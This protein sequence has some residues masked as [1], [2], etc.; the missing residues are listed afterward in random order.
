MLGAAEADALRAEHASD[1]RVLWSVSIRAHA[2]RADFIG[3][4]QQAIEV[5]KNLGLLKLH[6]AL[7]KNLN[8]FRRPRR[9]LAVDD[10]ASRAIDGDRIALF[11]RLV[12]FDAQLAARIVDANRSRADDARFAHAARHNCGMRGEPAARS[13][14]SFRAVH[15][16]D[17]FR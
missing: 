6:R 13:Q 2:E 10:F 17:V 7:E 4:L 5:P 16:G 11:E 9:E 14:D 15:S 12:A 1:A 3:P 8:D